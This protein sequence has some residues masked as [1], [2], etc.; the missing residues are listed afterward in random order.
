MTECKVKDNI[1]INK[2]FIMEVDLAIRNENTA[3]NINKQQPGLRHHTIAGK[4]SIVWSP[5]IP[6]ISTLSFLLSTI[7]A[8]NSQFFGYSWEIEISAFHT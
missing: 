6:T 3:P 1:Q 7:G 8:P 2:G 5:T 4:L